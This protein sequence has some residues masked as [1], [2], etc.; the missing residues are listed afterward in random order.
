MLETDLVSH[1]NSYIGHHEGQP[2]ARATFGGQLFIE[3]VST[4]VVE[5][6][7]YSL[8]EWDLARDYSHVDLMG[9]TKVSGRRAY[10]VRFT[11]RQRGIVERYYDAE[12]FL[13]LR[14]DQMQHDPDFK[15]KPDATYRVESYFSEYR[16]YGPL[17]LPHTIS[18]YLPERNLL[19]QII[20]AKINPNIS[21]SAFQ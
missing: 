1:G 5:Q 11:T 6:D 14:M 8:L 10:A 19:F 9:E 2:F 4:Q 16:D 7:Y 20:K 12:T 18:V 13:L 3:N 15:N 17:K 21:Y